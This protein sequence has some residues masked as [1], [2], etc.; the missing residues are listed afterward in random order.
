MSVRC[1]AGYHGLLEVILG[2]GTVEER[3]G[4]GSRISGYGINHAI[5]ELPWVRAVGCLMH[6]DSQ[7]AH[8]ASYRYI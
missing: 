7:A 2:Y 5:S 8:Q 3:L 1:V 4:M 6:V